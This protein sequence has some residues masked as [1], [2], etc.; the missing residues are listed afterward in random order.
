[1]GKFSQDEISDGGFLVRHPDLTGKTNI[2]VVEGNNITI[3]AQEAINSGKLKAQE[4]LNIET[5]GKFYNRN[6]ILLG[7]AIDIDTGKDFV[8]SI[9]TRQR[10]V[11]NGSRFYKV[12]TDV[13]TTGYI[14][15]GVGGLKINAGGELS[16]YAL[17]IFSSGDTYIKAEDGINMLGLKSVNFWKVDYHDDKGAGEQEKALTA[18]L[19]VYGDLELESIANKKDIDY[20]AYNIMSSKSVKMIS[21]GDINIEN[22]EEYERQEVETKKDDSEQ[23]YINE[24]YRNIKSSII[25]GGDIILSAA[26]EINIVASDL[27]TPDGQIS[28]TGTEVEIAAALDK[29][30]ELY[31]ESK[32]ENFGLDKSS[33]KEEKLKTTAV[34]SEIFAKG[35]TINTSSTLYDENGNM[36]CGDIKITGSNLTAGKD[37]ILLNSANGIYI[38]PIVEQ[39]IEARSSSRE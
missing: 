18:R 17:D 22:T 31:M 36:I 10:T 37:G 12:D 1:M 5:E 23:K 39:I 15:A 21:G 20:K 13:D 9:L 24:Q 16:L 35:I 19:F 4:G 30:Y 27:R 32:E 33:K 28:L 29:I 34:S 6:G 26:G 38:N 2:S 14:N 8:S 7:E 11:G 3:Q 25:A